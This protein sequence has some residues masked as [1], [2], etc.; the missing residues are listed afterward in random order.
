MTVVLITTGDDSTIKGIER[1]EQGRGAVT[2][3]V[4]SLGG[5][6]TSLQGQSGVGAVECLHLALLVAAQN[7]R[8]LGRG[9]IQAYDVL[10]LL[11]ELQIPRDLEAL[12][13][14]RFEAIGLPDSQHR[15]VADAGL[16]GERAR[17]PVCRSFG[18]G[19]RRQAHDL[20]SIDACLRP[21]RGRSSSIATTP[22]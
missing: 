4:M 12:D 3:V 5:R 7:Q 22:P 20:S 19:L 11:G 10:E 14:V 17:A 2:L 21:L 15:G 13:Q 18:R 9:H 1:R 6:A 16:P 8:M